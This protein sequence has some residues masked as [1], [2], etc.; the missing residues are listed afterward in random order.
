MA[1][2]EELVRI[3]GPE[4]VTDDPALM[5]GYSIDHNPFG[6]RRMPLLAVMPQRVEELQEITRLCNREKAAIYVRSSG[7]NTMGVANYSGCVMLDLY[8]RMRTIHEIDEEERYALIEPGVTAGEL[9][10]E[11]AKRGLR[12]LTGQYPY[13]TSILSNYLD[14]PAVS[15]AFLH[16]E[17]FIRDLEVVLP[18]GEVI[19]TGLSAVKGCKPIFYHGFGPGIT[20]LFEGSRGI[21][22]IITKA[23]VMLYPLPEYVAWYA[24]AFRDLDAAIAF[25]RE[26]A[27]RATPNIHFVLDA[28]FTYFGVGMMM[29]LLRGTAG[30]MDDIEPE[31]EREFRRFI[32]PWLGLLVYEGT[33]NQVKAKV[34]DL[35]EMAGKHEGVDL[36]GL[37]LLPQPFRGV[38]EAFGQEQI[39][40]PGWMEIL[41]YGAAHCIG[42]Y[43]TVGEMSLKELYPRLLDLAERYR[44]P[45]HGF[46]FG[47][48]GMG[49]LSPGAAYQYLVG[50]DS[51]NP[52]EVDRVHAWYLELTREFHRAGHCPPRLFFPPGDP[53]V[54]YWWSQAPEY[55][56]FIRRIK[57]MLD[58]NNIMNPGQ[59]PMG[60]V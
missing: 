33:E 5:A 34:L 27:W 57:R 9:Y 18:D 6:S 37:D 53:V 14:R 2:K 55:T 41:A 50:Y 46:L 26:V 60:E 39:S 58:P 4:N 22:G 10:R 54:D 38:V 23:S 43:W 20:E 24:I 32:P 17:K 8:P 3:V 36:A 59:L 35:K 21:F 11:T 45:H 47:A 16:G 15:E 19:R 51:S 44:L 25:S 42:L 40:R 29:R 31:A 12:P 1:L 13:T 30:T 56:R 48:K 28:G 7:I 52:E 49:L